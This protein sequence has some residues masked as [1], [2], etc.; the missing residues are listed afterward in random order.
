MISLIICGVMVGVV[1]VGG[2]PPAVIVEGYPPAVIVE[3]VVRKPRVLSSA[4]IV[5]YGMPRVENARSKNGTG[6]RSCCHVLQRI[7]QITAQ[8]KSHGL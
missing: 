8:M 4:M 7:K 2:F 6:E 1:D 3:A 5:R